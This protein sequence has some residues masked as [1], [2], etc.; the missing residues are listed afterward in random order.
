MTMEAGLMGK[1]ALV[2]G[3]S[4]GIGA[5]IARSLANAG[6][7]VALHYN[8]SRSAA[9]DLAGEAV[10]QR[11]G[12]EVF[13]ADLSQETA[14]AGMWRRIEHELGPVDTLIC[15]AGYLDETQRPIQSMSL[16]QWSRTIDRN[17]TTTFLTIREFFR[18]IVQHRMSDPSAVLIASMSGVWGQPGHC[19]YAA[20]KAAL[21]G[22]MLP[23][24]KDEIAKIAPLGRVNAIAP[25][26]VITSMIH[27]KL[28]DKNAMTKVLQTTSLR[29]FGIPDDVA[30]LATFL[31]SN[32]LSGHISG[33]TIRLTGGKEGRIL[34]EPS[35]IPMP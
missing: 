24:L 7:T 31:A 28:K 27:N 20:A 30:K 26:F 17:L 34:Y 23:T 32:S 3:A 19:D 12:C 4:G 22:G 15:N 33:E 35:E 16:E 21:V 9:L 25:G 13:E 14:V 18:G 5:A 2:T 8:T 11:A 6:A 10:F 1:V 29:K